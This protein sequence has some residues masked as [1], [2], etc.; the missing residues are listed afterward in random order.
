MKIGWTWILRKT[1]KLQKFSSYSFFKSWEWVQVLKSQWHIRTTIFSFY[2][3]P[4][5]W[6]PT[7]YNN[8]SPKHTACVLHFGSPPHWSLGLYM[9]FE[10]MVLFTNDVLPVISLR[11]LY[12]CWLSMGEHTNF[13]NKEIYHIDKYYIN[14]SFDCIPSYLYLY[15]NNIPAYKAGPEYFLLKYFNKCRN[16]NIH[17]Q[18]VI[19]HLVIL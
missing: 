4:H 13:K 7:G 9:L 12:Y 16:N 5:P 6:L 15:Y 10:V 19:Y 18:R 2:F 1:L 3:G 8:R 17:K 14:Y 11:P